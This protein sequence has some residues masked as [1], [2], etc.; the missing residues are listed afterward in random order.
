MLDR[1]HATAEGHRD[2]ADRLLELLER[3]P[4][5]PDGSVRT[6]AYPGSATEPLPVVVPG[7]SSVMAPTSGTVEL[8]V[9]VAL[10]SASDRT[11]TVRWRTLLAE[12]AELEQAPHAD[13]VAASGR[14][15]F[16]PGEVDATVA[17]TVIGNSTGRDEAVLVSFTDPTNAVVGGTWGLGVG[18]ITAAP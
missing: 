7:Q 4:P 16:A 12:D 8:R 14:V 2:I 1:N 17:I 15:T 18:T 13:Y 9:P 6:V 11:V 3:P 5:V 10:S